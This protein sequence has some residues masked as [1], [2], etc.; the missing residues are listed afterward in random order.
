MWAKLDTI[1]ATSA[2]GFYRPA[3]SKA[4]SEMRQWF[5]S[6]A[7]RRDL[8]VD[9]DRNG[10]LWAW[11][12]R[13]RDGVV[14]TGSHLDSVPD[15]GAFDGPLGVVAGF[16]AI[17]ELRGTDIALARPIAVACFSDEEGARFG[18]SCVGSRLACG[19]L[20]PDSARALADADGTTLAEAM[21]QAGTDPDYLGADPARLAALHAFVELHIE[22]GRAL[23]DTG[24]PV[25]VATAI[26]PHGR[27][28]CSFEGEPN[29][30]G[31]T[32]M[33]DRRDPMLALAATVTE[34][35]EAAERHQG[36]ATFA[37]VLVHPNATNAI[38][39]SVDAWLDARAADEVTLELLVS[40]VRKGAADASGTHNVGFRLTKESFS[41]PVKFDEALR[42]R[43]VI[44]LGA[45][46]E[47]PTAGGHDAGILAAH[48]PTAMLFVRNTT[49]VSH[50]PAE[51]AT[52]D[53]CVA[54]AHALAR[55]LYELAAQ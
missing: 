47:L 11:W 53:D 4:D 51:S 34:T 42:S 49:G 46:P 9:Q 50:S 12:G 36:R 21:R 48:V 1:G 30:A 14:A 29:H 45:V 18:V 38:A 43:V 22:Q 27:W 8:P 33:S 54:G 37:K 40:E 25:G 31:T 16:L 17:D 13:R 6:E 20:Q 3:W 28:R 39:V 7:M 35:R 32:L 15:G 2:G 23:I 41:A 26:W 52:L 44:A 5:R 55:V 19:E 24:A 10:N